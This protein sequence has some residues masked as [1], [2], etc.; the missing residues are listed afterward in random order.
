MEANQ[1]RLAFLLA[2]AVG[3]LA[4]LLKFALFYKV[5]IKMTVSCAHKHMDEFMNR[6][7]LPTN[8]RPLNYDLVISP[9]MTNFVFDGKV[10]IKY[11]LYTMCSNDSTRL[12]VIEETSKIQLNAKELAIKTATILAADEYN[13]LNAILL[14]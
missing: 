7:V 8:V 11:Y 3:V 14:Y 2:A 12:N 5:A 10:S 6:D 4:A 9:D 1:S 13:G